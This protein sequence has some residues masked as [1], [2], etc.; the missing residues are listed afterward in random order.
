MIDIAKALERAV[1]ETLEDKI[2]IAFSGGIDSTLIAKIAKAHSKVYL[3]CVGTQ[4][5]Q[6]LYYAEKVSAE[7]GLELKKSVLG[8]P[9]IIEIYEK[10][11]KIT[12]G[13]LLKVELM[14]P[15]YEVATMAKEEGLGVVLFG[16]GS[17]E[18]FVGYDRYYTYLTEG[19]DLDLILKEEFRTLKDRDI[20]MVKKVCYKLG[21]EARFPFYNRELA[22]LVFSVP[23]SERIA[24]K[25]LKKG[26]LREAAK[27]L[28]APKTA[29]ERRKKAMQYG[30]GVHKVLLKF[31]GERK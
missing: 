8:G 11:Q 1:E 12:P 7:L 9:K 3:F 4:E 21:I 20:G 10:C 24:D 19:K 16:S 15:V 14:V 25:E 22:D 31:F 30:S 5:S 26:V 27:L 17:E 29:I 2:G 13:D 23:L 18:L 28:G 6:D